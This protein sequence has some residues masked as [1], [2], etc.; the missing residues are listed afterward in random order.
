MSSVLAHL[1]KPVRRPTYPAYRQAGPWLA[2]E[3]SNGVNRGKG[4]EKMK[5]NREFCPVS[6]LIA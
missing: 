4:N 6:S 2:T 1:V 3:F 5:K